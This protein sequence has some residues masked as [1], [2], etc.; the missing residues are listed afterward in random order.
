LR[1]TVYDLDEIRLAPGVIDHQLMGEV[2]L[3]T[4]LR[5]TVVSETET[6]TGGWNGYPAAPSPSPLGLV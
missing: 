2:D 1:G 4:L 5:C 6:K 3:K